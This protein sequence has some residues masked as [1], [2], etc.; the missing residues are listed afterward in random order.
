MTANTL[1]EHAKYQTHHARGTLTH[2]NARP[3]ATP[4]LPSLVYAGAFL[5][6]VATPALAFEP[7]VANP[8]DRTLHDQQQQR[9]LD[10]AR[11]QREDLSTRRSAIVP[12]PRRAESSATG[13]AIA[14]Q[15]CV[16]VKAIDF[17]GTDTLPERLKH[18]LRADYPDHCLRQADLDRLLDEVNDWYVAHGYV[19]SHAWLPRQ[20][21]ADGVL[22]VEAVEGKLSRVYFSGS[23]NSGD[24]AARM[25]FPGTPGE[26]LNLRDIEQ[27]V[28]QIERVVPGGVRVAI[29][30]APAEGYSDVV[31]TGSAAPSVALN[32]SADNNGTE[33]TGRDEAGAALTLN[34]ALGLGEQIMFS[35]D[36]TVPVHSDRFRRNYGFSAALPVGY[37]TFSYAAAG[38]NYAIPLNIY[39]VDLRYHGRSIQHRLTAS[40]TVERN[41]RSKTDVFASLTHYTGHVYLDDFELQNSGERQS[42]AQIGVNFA[43]RVAGDSYLTLSPSITQ[44]LAPGSTDMRASAG[45]NTHFRKAALSASFYKALTQRV[46]YL[47][48]A[49]GQWTPDTLYGSE[50][51]TVGSDSSVRGFRDRYLYGNSGAYWRNEL[52]WKVAAPSW[53]GRVTLTAAIDAGRVI[54][55]AGEPAS[56]GNV[57]GAA[58]AASTAFKNIAGSISVG[59][60]LRSPAQLKADPLVVNI[61]LTTS[62]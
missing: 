43:T 11:T 13:M 36:A 18:R 32:L 56:G 29:R 34:N 15:R 37:W 24:R 17:R 35:G 2:G 58:L 44:G 60:P 38:G 5:A 4:A 19:T 42:A 27:G 33:N 55:V 23:D 25:A 30:P 28:D 47:S 12:P 52:I 6:T 50:R 57:I 62:F 40:R 45:P 8:V 10:E 31:L 7:V 61:R 51:I 26:P 3:A 59:T 41:A 22:I 14:E 53:A 1:H 9:M 54:P 16:E 21:L 49:Y 39:G 20:D 48:S 46:A